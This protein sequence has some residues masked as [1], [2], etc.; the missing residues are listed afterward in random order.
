MTGEN[1]AGVR[2]PAGRA[3]G[4]EDGAIG[5]INAAVAGNNLTGVDDAA[6]NGRGF[7]QVNAGASGGDGAGIRYHAASAAAAESR[8]L[9]DINAHTG[10]PRG[11]R[12]AIGDAAR[13]GGNTGK[14]DAGCAGDRYPSGIRD[15]AGAVRAENGH[16][17]EE[18]PD[19]RLDRDR[20]AVEDVS[21]ESGVTG[22]HNA[23]F[24]GRYRSA[25][26]DAA[27]EGRGRLEVDAG[28]RAAK[29]S[30]AFAVGDAPGK[31][32]DVKYIDA[33]L[34]RGNGPG[35]VDASGECRSAVSFNADATGTTGDDLAG[36][37]DLDAARNDAAAD[38]DTEIGRQNRPLS[39]IAPLMVLSERTAIPV[40]APE[41][42]LVLRNPPL[43]KV[44]LVIVTPPGPMVPA[45][46]TPPLNVVAL[47]TMA[48][49]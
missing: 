36:G 38:Q 27:G 21:G 4:P 48:V 29:D 2:Y 9:A 43:R 30:S 31:D 47:I 14:L 22:D 15:T 32:G 34:A 26:G 25:V 8:D 11:N 10:S 18:Y 42:R 33:G 12:A 39:L 13:K 23:V 5:D 40:G 45:L 3:A 46:V 44:L 24:R 20:A 41:M 16:V 37:G 49:V 19:V 1:G 6:E 28:E 35:I 7:E 17:A